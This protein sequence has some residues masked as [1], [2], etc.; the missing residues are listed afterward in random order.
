VKI[1]IRDINDNGPEF[2]RTEYVYSIY[3]DAQNGRILDNPPILIF[4]RDT[5][6]L[7]KFF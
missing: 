2:D 6:S 7:F 3:E 5:V 4:D 1:Q